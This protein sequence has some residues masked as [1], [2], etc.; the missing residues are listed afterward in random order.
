MTK[1]SLGDY[2]V[3]DQTANKKVAGGISLEELLERD[4][5]Y[6]VT[7]ESIQNDPSINNAIP[8]QFN[9]DGSLKYTFDNIYENRQLSAVAKDYYRNRDDVNL[10]DKEAVN[11]FISDRTW[12]QS[13]TFAMGK[14]FTYITGNNVGEDQKARLSYLTR[15]WDELPNFYEEGGRGASGFFANLGVAVLDPLNIIGAGVGGQVAKGVLKKAGQE[16]IKAQTKKGITKKAIKKELL[17][18][19]EDLA[20]LSAKARNNAII[21]GSASVSAVEGAGFG[22]IDIANQ[23]VEREIG[24]RETLD[25]I[26][27]GTV[28]MT[29]AG[30]GFFVPYAGGKITSKIANLRLAKNNKLNNEILKKHSK[31]QPDNTGKSEG[32]NSPINGELSV[33]SK[34]RT[35]LADQWDFIKVLQKEIT[36]VGGDVTSLKN[37]YT[38]KKGF[39]D[40]VTK[41][42]VDPILQPYFQLRQLA[43]SGTRGHHFIMNGVYLPPNPAARSASYKKGKSKGLHQ[44]LEK[45]DVDNEVNEFLNYVASKRI[46][47][48]SKRRPA[49]EKTLPINKV[50][51]KNYIDFAELDAATYKKRYGKNLTR[52]NNFKKALD[53]YKV[54]TD[55]LLEYQV[56]SGL[57]NRLD[58]RKIK[59]E[60]PFFIPLTRETEKVGLI[61]AAGQQTRKMLGIARPGAVKLATKAQEGNINL[62]KN[63]LTYTYQTVLAG[64]RNRAKIS[65]YNMLQKGDKLGTINADK[66]V[67]KVTANRRV[68]IENIAVD[69][70]IRAYEKSGA[71]FDPEKVLGKVGRKRKNQLDNLDS[72]DVLTFS[73]TFKASDDAASDVVDIVYRNGKA[74]IYE[75]IDP[76]L[77]DLFNGLSEKGANKVM[78]GFGP[79]G[80][81]SIYARFASRAITYTP[82]FVAFNLIRDTLAGAVNSAFGIGPKKFLPVYS[83]GK[84][85]QD[86]VFQTHNYKK[87]LINGMGYSSRSETEAFKPKNLKELVKSGVTTS[88]K[89]LGDAENYYSNV[90]KKYA[91]KIGAGGRGYAKIVQAAEY[92]TR[93]GEFQLAKAAGFSDIGASFLGREVATDFG[94]RGSNAILNGLSRNTM[95]LNASIQ[96]LYRTY[97]LFGEDYKKAGA[98]ITATVVAPEI[99]LYFTNA[100]FKEYS[101]VP[102]QVKQLNYLLPNIDFAASKEQGRIELDKEVPFIPF[103]KPYDLGVFANIAVG[104]I[105]GMLKKSAGVSQK[106]IAESISQ[107]MPGTPIPAGVRPIFELMA[108]KNLYS[109]APVLGRYELQRLDELQARPSTREIARKLSNFSSNIAAFITR[110]PEGGVKPVPMTPIVADYLL[111]AYLTGMMQYPVDILENFI[112][113]KE[114][115]GPKAEKREDQAD[116]SS[117]LSAPSIVTRRFKVAAPIKN[118]EYHKQWAKLISRA[119]KLKQID[120]SQMDLEKRN[121]S[122]IIG[123]FGRTYEKMKEGFEPGVEPE[124]LNFAGISD[125]LKEGEQ[126][127]LELRTQRNNIAES[128]IDAKTK[129]EL[130]DNIISVE[131]MYLK[132]TID[133][134]ASIDEL[135]FIFDQTIGD[136]MKDLGVIPGL[137][138]ILLGGDAEDAFKPN[139]LERDE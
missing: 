104:L 34:I 114:E 111:G 25:P 24:L 76:N 51:R 131:N 101:Q 93:M 77:A 129:R 35:N 59:K 36:G 97:R 128:N 17:N 117:F 49:L 78:Y 58:A 71:K 110:T 88:S 108:N 125:V 26:R 134:L 96:G 12:K 6:N 19:P 91:K 123:L 124:V 61:T 42:K 41:K 115:R 121:Q 89:V 43:S 20:N 57:I 64:D 30:L 62:Y 45:L 112:P 98:L 106:Y 137:F 52:K 119:K 22:T 18:S 99:A 65:L 63:L 133:N 21:K 75:V 109:G 11:K 33:G 5:K 48:I 10:T 127:M 81:F 56:Q 44:I 92:G 90:I 7:K 85:F 16:V 50:E 14:E 74:E 94:M 67:R 103:P 113:R 120:T 40:P 31:K 83:T 1:L 27:T 53:Q 4:K 82:P 105:D 130:I 79:K 80:I 47:F 95:F 102:D 23:V 54:F 138:S 28:A 100:R 72:L 70:V 135:D 86:A 107:I 126:Y 37:I 68:R 84:G 15:Y 46:N 3:N 132:A 116:L 73:N 139:P 29:A 32:V 2:V 13:N 136:N 39:I 118:S 69:K 66:V 9:S 60:N 87:A 55:E 122:Y 8:V 38:S